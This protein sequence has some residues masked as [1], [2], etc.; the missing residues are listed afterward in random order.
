FAIPCL[1]FLALY[2]LDF[3]ATFDLTMIGAFYAGALICFLLGYLSGRRLF[4]MT[5]GESVAIGFAAFFSNSVLLGLAITERAYGPDAL[6]PNFALIAIHAPILYLVGI[7]AMEIARA[8]GRGAVATARVT[9][10]AMFSNPISM[11]C[12][13]GIAFNLAAVPLPASALDAGDMLARTGL[14]AALFGLGGV[15][16]RY[17]IRATIGPAAAVTVISALIHPAITYLLTSYLFGIDEGLVR[18]AT[19]MAAMAP[20]VN[21]YVFSVM[22]DRATG[23]VA[24]SVIVATAAS[25][26]TT[27]GWLWLLGGASI[28]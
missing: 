18:S 23:A 19:I 1:L 15:L 12:G 26:F 3:S 27:A 16:S 13:A 6:A 2:R 10:I 17:K 20:G 4:G 7:T 14:P 28:G 25:V 24:T 5:P 11:S 8:D 21:A 22:Y 9:L